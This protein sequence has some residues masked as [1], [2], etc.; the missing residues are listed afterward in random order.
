M[1]SQLPSRPSL[2]HLRK[3]AKALLARL[4]QQ[5]PNVTLVD[6]QHALARGS[7]FASWPKLKAHVEALAAPP[8]PLTFDRYTEKARQA[9]FFSRYEASQLGSRTIEPEHLLVALIRTSQG[10]KGRLFE[11]MALSADQA[12]EAMTPGPVGEQLPWSVTIPFGDP[13]RQIFRAAVE[14][15]DALEHESIGLAHI[16]LGVLRGGESAAAR[17]LARRGMAAPALRADIE[18]LLDEER[19]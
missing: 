8:L 17:L 6:A 16:L 13:T 5:N 3:Q 1:S 2:S 7:G 11:R 18:Q 12:R 4:R 14:E 10:L 15:A 19:A 9:L